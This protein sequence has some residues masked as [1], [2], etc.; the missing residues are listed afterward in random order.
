M[1][2][3][4]KISECNYIIFCLPTPLQHLKQKPDIK[5]I[6]L[7]FKKIQP[8]LKKN[9]TIILESTVFPGATQKIFLPYLRKKFSV[10]KNFFLGYSSERISPG[11]IDKKIYKFN[12]E[13]TTKVISG[14]NLKSLKIINSFYKKVFK[15]IHKAETIEIAETSKLLEN[16]YRAVNIGLVN[17]LKMVCHK[18]DININQVIK[19]ASTKPFGFTEFNPGPGV[20]GHCIPIDPIFLSWIASKNG[21]DTKFINLARLTNIKVTNWTLNRIVEKEPQ[22]RNKKIRKKI[23]IIGLAYKPDVNDVRESPSIKI[24]KKL[25]SFN[26]EVDYNDDHIPNIIINNKLLYSTSLKKIKKYDVVIIATNHSNLRKKLILQNAKKIFDTRG[27]Y[28]LIDSK[29]IINI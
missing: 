7:A 1:N 21:I 13:N 29:K 25:I 6:E 5:K 15:S 26:N 3:L 22:I 28:K 10:G 8:Y 19:A 4:V 11:Q 20:G 12:L 14:Y 16:S 18:L 23:L 27:V 24:L 9:Q 17:E 2:N